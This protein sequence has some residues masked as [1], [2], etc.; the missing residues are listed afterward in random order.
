MTDLLKFTEEHQEDDVTKLI[1]NRDKWPEIDIE[2]AVNTI[3]SRRKLKGKVD[4]WAEH[5]DLIF[6]LTLS[7]EQ[8]SS[9]VTGIYKA[10]LAEKIAR[11][12]KQDSLGGNSES[13]ISTRTSSQD[14]TIADLTGGLG[15]DTWYFSQKAS[16]VLYNEM[17]ESLY[18]ATKYNL[19]RL[20]VH[21]VIFT[22]RII[23]ADDERSRAEKKPETANLK[24][25]QKEA[26]V[27][28]ILGD[29]QPTIIYLDPARRGEGGKKVFLLEDCSPDVLSLK[30]ELFQYSRHILLK[31]SP[32]ADITMLIESLGVE[33]K[34]FHVVSVDGE[35]KEILV[36][37]DREYAGVEPLIVAYEE[38]KRMG[39]SFEFFPSEEKKAIAKLTTKEEL[40]LSMHSQRLDGNIFLFEPNKSLMKAGA[41]NLIAEK[42]GI[43]KL[44]N[45][46]HFYIH[47]EMSCELLKYGKLNSIHLI[48]PF[49]NKT[50]RSLGKD[51]PEADLTA[52]NLPI[53][54]EQL[55]KKMGLD[56]K[57]KK[58]EHESKNHAHIYALKVD[59]IGNLFFVTINN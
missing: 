14:W 50:I 8:C 1:L 41:F 32:M 19:E 36:W 43:N 58:N 4:D 3:V 39:N 51:Y 47:Q 40:G 27:K 18:Q 35:C 31:L 21:N 20:G 16:K 34:E 9:Q 37:M 17:Q 11:F 29:F 56:N 26:S 55:R 45:S 28:E 38:K 54:T 25:E 24:N 15:V 30:S 23:V 44:G 46:T 49:N 13:N 53:T 52:R 2:L 57:G 10:N 12:S 48:Y 5:P 6:P 7:A 22:N 59:L 33:T 42:F